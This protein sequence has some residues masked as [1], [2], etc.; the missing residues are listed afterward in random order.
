[1]E[2]SGAPQHIIQEFAQLLQFHITTYIDNT[3]PG[4][5]VAQQRSGRPIK[6]ISQRLK[7]G[8]PLDLPVQAGPC[9]SVRLR[10]S[11]AKPC[12]LVLID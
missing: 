2:Q 8:R 1:M 7:V 9:T 11:L 10:D 6:S 3:V 5:P 4:Q 12:K